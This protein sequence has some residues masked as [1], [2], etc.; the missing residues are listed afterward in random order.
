MND[1]DQLERQEDRK[2]I[3]VNN[4]DVLI[5]E[6]DTALKNWRQGDSVLGKHW[7]VYRFDPQRPLTSE[8]DS[9]KHEETD[10]S[11]TEVM[12]FVVITQTCDIV[13][14]CKDRPF[15]EVVPLIRVDDDR[16]H[17]VQ[18]CKRPQFAYISGVAQHNLVADLDRVMTLEKA[19][20][21]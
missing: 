5:H 3:V 12:G 13:R 21:L 18:R 16:L 20:I 14:S 6:V 11:A 1:A 9:I 19:V 2:T 7:F 17:E 8:S 15:I 10:L 4:R